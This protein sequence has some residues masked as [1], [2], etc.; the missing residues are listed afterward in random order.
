M[1]HFVSCRVQAPWGFLVKG[2][3]CPWHDNDGSWRK[4]RRKKNLFVKDFLSKSALWLSSEDAPVE[5][6]TQLIIM[7]S[8]GWKVSPS[9]YRMRVNLIVW[10]R[11]WNLINT[12]LCSSS[13]MLLLFCHLKWIKI[14][15][16]GKLYVKCHVHMTQNEVYM[17]LAQ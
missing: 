12:E 11:D 7:T 3:D 9:D 16:N 13:H 10:W 5:I 2:E 1:C 4:N 15:F 14:L 6:F 17:S 8:E